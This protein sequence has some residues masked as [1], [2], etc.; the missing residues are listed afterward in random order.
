MKVDARETRLRPSGPPWKLV[1][2]WEVFAWNW[3][4]R[5]KVSQ[6]SFGLQG[7]E[8]NWLGSWQVP[9]DILFEG[10]RFGSGFFFVNKLKIVLLQGFLCRCLIAG[11]FFCQDWWVE[12]CHILIW[13]L[14]I[15]FFLVFLYS[16]LW[17]KKKNHL[18]CL[19]QTP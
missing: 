18:L 4:I 11:R 19:A 9:L 13:F 10:N 17:I 12:I 6:Q 2:T 7:K 1:G 15:L 16:I 3:V 8:Y 14:C 5:Q